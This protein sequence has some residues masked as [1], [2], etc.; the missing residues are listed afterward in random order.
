MFRTAQKRYTAAEF[1]DITV[2]TQADGQRVLLGDLAEIVDGFED[3]YVKTRLDGKSAI[4]VN[5]F[6]VGNEDTRGVADAAKDVIERAEAFLPGGVKLEI[7]NDTSVYLKGRMGL[8]AKNGTFGLILVF[9][10]LALFLRPSLAALVSIGI[11]VSF[12][13]AIMMMPWL[14]VSI[15]MISL[16]GFILVL[17][18]VV[19][20]AIVVGENVYRRM[21]EGEDPKLA[22]PRG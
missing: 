7:W 3:V 4:L 17:G 11:P 1:R 9:L 20:D 2:V 14:G 18:I 21:R 22:A 10:V 15:N 8:L 16:F 12:A 6:R 19:D 5:V 13:G